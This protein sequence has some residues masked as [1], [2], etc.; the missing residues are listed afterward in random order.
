MTSKA[1]LFVLPL[2][3][4]HQRGPVAAWATTAGWALGA[5]QVLGAAWVI[6]DAGVLSPAEAAGNVSSTRRGLARPRRQW[7]RR[8]LPEPAITLAKDLRQARH[9]RRS[10]LGSEGGPWTRYDVPFVWQRHTLFRRDGLALSRKLDVPLVLSVHALQVEEA[11][12]WGVRR[13]GW[14]RYAERWGEIPQL[15]AA[16]LLACVSPAVAELVAGRGIPESRIL[17]T[18]N[19]VDLDHFSPRQEGSRLREDLGLA[20]C[21]VVGWSGSFRRFHGL[22][23][24]MAVMVQL[25]Q[26]E[27]NVRLLM[28]G[29]GE[30]RARLERHAREL[31]LTNVIF[32]GSV[33]YAEMP[34]YLAA[35]D[36]GL[37]LSP[38]SGGFHYSPVKLREYMACGLPVVAPA[39]GEMRESLQNRTEAILIDPGDVNALI[40]AIRLLAHDPQLREDLSRRGV[41]LARERWD[42]RRQVKRVLEALGQS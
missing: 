8:L 23:L 32:A 38:E 15:Q 36:V 16:D 4:H 17:V 42:W 2:G 1:G 28:I 30:E 11:A 7:H 13:P 25:E 29:D 12:S 18:P 35:C 6:S 5:E 34:T 20:D 40:D 27:P 26:T 21:F 9:G 10:S 31:G 3:N 22:D 33:T 14:Q 19:G 41:R 39:V 37:V 24:A